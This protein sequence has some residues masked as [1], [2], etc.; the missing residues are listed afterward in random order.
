VTFRVAA[1]GTSNSGG[2]FYL[3]DALTG[4]DLLL[5]GC[6][7]I[8]AHYPKTLPPPQNVTA[9]SASASRI[10]VKW[11]GV[12]YA[13]G[14]ALDLYRWLGIPRV[15]VDEAFDGCRTGSGSIA[16]NT[17]PNATYIYYSTGVTSMTALPGW[18][19]QATSAAFTPSLDGK[20]TNYL[21]RV[22]SGGTAGWI[23]T[24][25]LN[26]GKAGDVT[27]AFDIIAWSNALERTT[28]DLIVTDTITGV[29][30]TNA[31]AGLSLEEMQ[32]RAVVFPDAPASFTV[33]FAAQLN[34]PGNNRF[35]LDNVTVSGGEQYSL[36]FSDRAV[37]GTVAKIDG[38]TEG[39]TYWGVVR[40]VNNIV[41]LVSHDSDEFEITLKAPGTVIIIR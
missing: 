26:V 33:R 17:T 15:P 24:P 25:P 21:V 28:I 1:W 5:K 37:A 13:T 9:E 41:H 7:L 31:V 16:T 19:M 32:S 14:Y 12:P 34:L 20:T 36:V 40:S 2:G 29:A 30:V 22:G 27:V 8:D 18:S 11:N 10:T 6:T 38:L 4:D 23:Q 3:R 35:F 39:V